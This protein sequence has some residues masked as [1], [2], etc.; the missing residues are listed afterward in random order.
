MGV[1]VADID[2]DRLSPRA[3]R[4]F[5]EI[6]VPT[7]DGAKT[8]ELADQLGISKAALRAELAFVREELE[9]QVAGATLPDLDHDS[10]EALVASIRELGQL[11]PILVDQHG[12]ILDGNHRARA[13]QELGLRPVKRKVD[14][15]DDDRR[16]I[17]LAVNVAR[18]HL[19]QT[20]RRR[21]IAAEL[22]R[23]PDASDRTIARRVGASPTT[24]GTVRHQLEEDG[25]VSRLDTRTDSAGRRQ[26]AS[27]PSGAAARDG[28]GRR[29]LELLVD[30]DVYE[31]LRVGA[32]VPV[33]LVTEPDG[34]QALV[35]A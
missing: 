19:S 14:V 4:A 1:S 3:R 28:E 11:V 21:M 26:P 10:Y 27:K 30:E 7:A 22:V 20:D 8:E 34:R 16:A 33:R 18:R 17:A 24:V 29:L 32:T 12:Q 13:V 23:S 2:V 6:V 5:D 9:A 31:Q 35:L 25:R 15:N